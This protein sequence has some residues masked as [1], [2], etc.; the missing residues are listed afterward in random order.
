MKRKI[1]IAGAVIAVVAALIYLTRE[2]FVHGRFL[3]SWMQQAVHASVEYGTNNPT[4]KAD[5]DMAIRALGTNA[6]PTL[7][8]ELHAGDEELWQQTRFTAHRWAVNIRQKFDHDYYD[9]KPFNDANQ[10][11][12]SAVLGFQALDRA[13]LPWLSAMVSDPKTDYLTA[14]HVAMALKGIHPDGSAVSL[15]VLENPSS[16]TRLGIMKGLSYFPRITNTEFKVWVPRLLDLLADT[17]KDAGER[18][19]AAK[20]MAAVTALDDRIIPALISRIPDRTLQNGYPEIYLVLLRI[21]AQLEPYYPQLREMA[22]NQT[23]DRFD[24]LQ[25]LRLT[26]IQVP[27]AELSKALEERYGKT[28]ASGDAAFRARYGK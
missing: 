24:R 26:K 15:R 12:I 28:T 27:Q 9:D 16:E 17:S 4:L 23:L 25:L 8:A 3:T 21:K 5:S 10:R 6:I 22:D 1:L 2:P 18:L 14:T 20:V 19:A 7:L 13:G 11:R